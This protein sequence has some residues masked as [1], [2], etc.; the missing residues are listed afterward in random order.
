M[1]GI[2][3]VLETDSEDVAWALQTADALWLRSERVDALVW[4][5]RAAQAAGDADDNNRALELARTA[6]ELSEWMSLVAM[7]T[8][9][10]E[11]PPGPAHDSIEELL[12]ASH[13]PDSRNPA[14]TAEE[15]HAG[16]L[17]PWS[18]DETQD[19]P[20]RARGTE[21]V[22]DVRERDEV[23]ETLTIMGP[24]GRSARNARPL[25]REIFDDDVVTSAKGTVISPASVAQT[26]PI[27]NR[28]APKAIT[29]PPLPIP[30]ETSPRRGQPAVPAPKPPPPMN[31]GARK[32]PP[33]LPPTP[34]STP[35]SIPPPS[36]QGELVSELDLVTIPPAPPSG[37]PGLLDS[38]TLDL[39]Q[40]TGAELGA[41]ESITARLVRP[42]PAAISG[43]TEPAVHQ[44]AN[45]F[46]L[47]GSA[48][49]VEESIE[50]SVGP[51]PLMEGAFEDQTE[52]DIDVPDRREARDGTDPAPPMHDAAPS[53]AE[54]VAARVHESG[55]LT[56]VPSFGEL[57]GDAIDS[58]EDLSDLA[59][60]PSVLDAMPSAP[61]RA[62]TRAVSMHEEGGRQVIELEGVDALSD[63]PDE[64]R[65]AFAAQA[66]LHELREDDEV[67]TFALALVLSGDVDVVATVLD[68]AEHLPAGT[69]LRSRGTN[70]KG[71]QLR[72]VCR[73]AEAR[74]ATWPAGPV[75]AAFKSCPWVEDDLRIATD[76]IQ[77]LVGITSGPLADRLDAS[78]REEIVRKMTTRALG[79]NEV[80]FNKGEPVGGLYLVGVNG[81]DLFEGDK[82]VGSVDVGDF[83]FATQVLGGGAAPQTVRAPEDGAVILYADRKAAQE[84]ISTCP[85]LLEILAGM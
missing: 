84:L 26:P 65:E 31:A 1:H 54:I 66:T 83:V 53:G 55:T 28:P 16:M 68:A 73:S 12:S 23:N 2:P 44:A 9:E 70:E 72:L 40:P 22:A 47:Q 57:R 36:D 8:Q 67:V 3:P 5:R 10:S 52:G 51:R 20:R 60:D 71:F 7:H 27:S 43:I 56:A 17:H 77:A 46:A 38:Q 79:S 80:L 85:P 78:L 48:F 59:A 4:L 39:P 25:T 42:R 63:L 15:T 64:E 19:Q 18:E 29:V 45:L 30:F 32:P 61:I 13:R 69:V 24:G 14:P 37:P 33:P 34:P 35:D 82:Q 75:E 49:S 6:A 21:G 11:P 74:V 41:E 81:L 50:T 62:A 76:R 58:A